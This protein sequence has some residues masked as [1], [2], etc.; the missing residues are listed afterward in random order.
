MTNDPQEEFVESLKERL[1][2]AGEK[3]VVIKDASEASRK[4]AM[5]NIAEAFS[6]PVNDFIDKKSASGGGSSNDV[7]SYDGSVSIGH[8]VNPVTGEPIT[9]LSVTGY[10]ESVVGAHN[11][12]LEAHPDIREEIARVEAGGLKIAPPDHEGVGTMMFYTGELL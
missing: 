5:E 11:V 3:N 2:I 7:V 1:A 6:E 4:K 8:G 9:N 10:V 12:N